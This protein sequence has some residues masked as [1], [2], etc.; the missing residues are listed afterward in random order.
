[1]NAFIKQ[2]QD[3]LGLYA[4]V[5]RIIGLIFILTATFP[6]LQLL[7]FLATGPSSGSIG[8]AIFSLGRSLQGLLFGIIIWGAAQLIKYV[9]TKQSRP[10]W[11][12][13]NAIIILYL[14]AL[15]IMLP[16]LSILQTLQ[17][18][19]N[20]LGYLLGLIIGVAKMMLVIGLANIL[21][22]LIPVIEESKKLAETA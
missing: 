11:L 20:I 9:S 14:G 18:L 21:K 5:A 13:R 6:I 4:A 3:M 1:M 19:P 10:P 7:S 8:V 16:Y 22:K 12:L 2:N 15:M 17:S